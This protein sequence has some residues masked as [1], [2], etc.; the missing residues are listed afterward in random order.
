MSIY[1][2]SPLNALYAVTLSLASELSPTLL[3]GGGLKYCVPGCCAVRRFNGGEAA[4]S[5]GRLIAYEETIAE[6]KRRLKEIEQ[7][8]VDPVE[9]LVKES[10]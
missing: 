8:S 10:Q 1:I 5:G 6:L 9:D 2:A 4:S 7:S 3:G